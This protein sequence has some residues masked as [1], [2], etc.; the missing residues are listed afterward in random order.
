MPLLSTHPGGRR[1]PRKEGKE[2]TYKKP[3]WQAVFLDLIDYLIVE[4][5]RV[6]LG[7]EGMKRGVERE[8][9]NASSLGSLE[10]RMFKAGIQSRLTQNGQKRNS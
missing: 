1:G 4:Y 6:S 9:Y 3:D 2:K 8:Q 5:T 7:R 10:V